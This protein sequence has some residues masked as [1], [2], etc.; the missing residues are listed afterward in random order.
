MLQT[1]REHTQGWF[2]G[3]IISVVILSFSLW[4]VHSYFGGSVNSTNVAEVNGIDI[5]K[6]QLAVAYERLRRQVQIQYGSNNPITSKD[7]AALKNRAMQTLIDIEVL[8]QAST[9]QG[10]R[11]S[12]R[13][14]DNY[15]RSMPEFQVDGQFS[16]DKFQE[17]L[18]STLLST[19]EF[20]DLIRTSLLIDQ[21]K[22]G[23]IFTSFA[24]P[25]ETK[26]TIE[27]VNQERDLDYMTIP[28]Q[29]N[30]NKAITIPQDKIQAYY[31][32]N[33][34]DFM[35]PEQANIEYIQLTI[36][37]LADKIT[38]TEAM[39]K[40]FY[41]EN[42]NSYTQ[43][44]QWKYTTIEFPLLP[45]ATPEEA[46][47]VA[48]KAAEAA[49]AIQSGADIAKVAA[50]YSA[51]MNTENWT[52][53]AQVSAELQKPVS[54]LAK[55]GDSS[56]PFK[57]SK[58]WMIVKAVD[59]Q[60]PKMLSFEAVK[61]KVKDAY[62]HQHA[63]EK[64]AEIR[65]QL[66]ELTY[67]HPDSLQSAS[68]SLNLPIQTS[69]LF[70]KEKPGKDIS[71]YKKVREIAFSNDVLNLQSN[72]DVIL[73]NPETAVVI[74]IKSHVASKLLPLTEIS[75]QIEDKLKAKE[76]ENQAATYANEI[77]K[78]LDAGAAPEKVAAEKS[79]KWVKT[80]YI[81]RYS[82]KVD[83]A[84]LDLAFRLPIKSDNKLSFG[85]T[86]LSNGYA[87]VALKSVKPGV[88]TDKKQLSVYSE[89]MQN[90]EGM[91]EYQLYKQSVTNAAKIKVQS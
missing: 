74:R 43:P 19:S 1:I 51:N 67:E 36:K 54:G 20:L 60:E 55:P 31:D 89:Q 33:K 24:L 78:Q 18:S 2:A 56:D 77:K 37:D 61:S 32:E 10:F 53:L 39:L 71:Q 65:D 4:G 69:E 6:E 47:A 27:L 88:V 11:V 25:D 82:T 66:A 80:G 28:M 62:V 42:I 52:A 9:A 70:T 26:N 38:P 87:I 15:L 73:V 7:E 29:S 46:T 14:I 50:Q 12:D 79:L 34:A 48:N 83:T 44:T 35:T 40:T 8:K 41:N 57:T 91:L 17:I 49:K 90:S 45:T 23:M 22:M 75:K 85:V 64:F 68:K 86:R 84:I 59:I 21:P 13:Q 72:S 58:G 3:T 81:G 63:E 5:T 30:A 16:F 76:A